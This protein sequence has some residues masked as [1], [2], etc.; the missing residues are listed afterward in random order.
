MH[1][2]CHPYDHTVVCDLQV[3]HK[4]R[5][6]KLA[7]IAGMALK[8][9]EP[10]L[11]PQTKKP[12]KAAAAAAAAAVMLAEQEEGLE[13]A[14]GAGWGDAEDIMT[15]VVPSPDSPYADLG[16]VDPVNLI[17][18]AYQIASGMVSPHRYEASHGDAP[19]LPAGSL[20]FESA[21]C[22]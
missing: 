11:V 10:Y 18:F 9:P 3:T 20:I 21:G 16:G 14:V 1:V 15:S 19:R 13:G 12:A 8:E 2:T 4:N 7:K 6:R 22:T 5:Q 17:S